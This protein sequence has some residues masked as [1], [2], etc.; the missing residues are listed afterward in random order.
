M[1]L[2]N[3]ILF[4]AVF[5]ITFVVCVYPSFVFHPGV[6]CLAGCVFGKGFPLPAFV[7]HKGGIAT[8]IPS[9]IEVRPEVLIINIV[10]TIIISIVI[11]IILSKI[12]SS[13]N[14]K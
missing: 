6:D 2:K 10:F 13:K 5:L 4:F 7:S 3:F 9:T 14:D 1:K 8:D 11:T 12:L